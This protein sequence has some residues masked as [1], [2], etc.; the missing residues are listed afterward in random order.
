RRSV[1]RAWIRTRGSG[2]VIPDIDTGINLNHEELKNQSWTNKGELR[3]DKN[4]N[5]KCCNG[6][7][8]D[9]NGYVDDWRGWDF[10]EKDNDP[11]D[12][13]GYGHGTGT[14]GIAAAEQNNGR[15]IPGVAPK[16]K[17]MVRRAGDTY[18]AGPAR[19]AEAIYYAE[20]G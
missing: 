2:T 1:D 7:D 13:A 14:S 15:G 12:D 8:D 6:I 17:L 11:S 9:H 10:Y 20:I 16:A 18:I 4:G 5:Q 3:L 19:V